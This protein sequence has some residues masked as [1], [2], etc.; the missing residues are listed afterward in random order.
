MRQGLFRISGKNNIGMLPVEVRIFI[1]HENQLFAND[2]NRTELI[3]NNLTAAG[4]NLNFQGEF[5][6]F[7]VISKRDN[8][9]DYFRLKTSLDDDSLE[10]IINGEFI[11]RWERR[12]M[13]N[14]ETIS[15][16]VQFARAAQESGATPPIVTNP[17]T[18]ILPPTGNPT[19]TPVPAPVPTTQ[20]SILSNPL[21]LIGG[22]GVLVGG[23]I[24]LTRNRR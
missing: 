18:P 22:A 17:T 3:S 21:F 11:K 14:A 2:D 1:D 9:D 24:L 7:R 5:G 13:D 15:E 12:E 10:L 23:I 16:I 20:N 4:F 19:Q 6:L 8:P